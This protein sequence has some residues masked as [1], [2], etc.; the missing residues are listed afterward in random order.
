[1]IAT[2]SAHNLDYLKSLGADEVIDYRATRF[3]DVVRGVDVVLDPIAGETQERSWQVLKKGGIL[4]S[5]LDSSAPEKAKAHGVRG[6]W[7]LVRPEAEQLT[8]LS[9]LIDAGQMRVVVSQVL[10]LEEIRRAQELIA[11]RHTRGKIVLR[12]V[13]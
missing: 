12:V 9:R 2:G 8:E 3:E 10:P 6:A 11:G 1:M 4:V 13:E 7:F 5:L